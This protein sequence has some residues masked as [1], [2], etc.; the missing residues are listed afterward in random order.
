M[1]SEEIKKAILN[2]TLLFRATRFYFSEIGVGN[3]EGETEAEFL[4]GIGKYRSHFEVH[5]INEKYIK[6]NF[7]IEN[8]RKILHNKENRIEIIFGWRPSKNSENE[9]TSLDFMIEDN[10]IVGLKL[11]FMAGPGLS[12][13]IRTISFDVKDIY[14]CP[15]CYNTFDIDFFAEEYVCPHCGHTIRIK[16]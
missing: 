15:Q 13:H 16:R 7:D 1:V 4:I 5:G 3:D 8:E 9:P 2:D 14:Y 6:S 12:A 11:W 10:R